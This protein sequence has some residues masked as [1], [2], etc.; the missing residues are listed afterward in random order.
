MIRKSLIKGR[1]IFTAWAV[2]ATASLGL[3]IIPFHQVGSLNKT[4]GPD[5]KLAVFLVPETKVSTEVLKEKIINI[6][7]ILSLINSKLI[8]FYY[9]SYF[10]YLFSACLVKITINFSPLEGNRTPINALEERCFIH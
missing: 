3:L 4:F 1:I 5:A 6:K 10:S 8:D 7:F 9:K 2:V